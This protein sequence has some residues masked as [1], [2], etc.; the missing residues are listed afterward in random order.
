MKPTA[1]V[2]LLTM[3]ACSGKDADTAPADDTASEDADTDADTDTDTS[4]AYGGVLPSGEYLLGFAVAPV[5]NLLVPFQA[6]VTP[7]A[8]GDRPGIASLS[9]APTSAAY[10]VGEVAVTATDIRVEADGSFVVDLGVFI[11]PGAYAPT[12]SDVELT[13]TL[14]G[15]IAED[16]TM[17]GDLS[18][19]LLSFG[20]SLEGSTFG[21]VAWADRESGAE[22]S[23]DGGDE[24]DLP[25]ITDCPTLEAGTV[26]GFPSGGVERTFE[27]V[28]PPGADT[29]E[30]M[31]VVFAFHGLGG[32]PAQFLEDH[33]LP[34]A[35][36][37]LGAIVVVPRATD[38]GG[39]E[40]W[41]PYSSPGGNKDVAFF[42]DM[43]T[44]VSEQYPVDPDRVHV[45]GFSNGGLVTGMLLTVRSSVIASVAPFAGGL[46]Q[47]FPDDA[48]AI[49]T[50]MT[51]G[52]PEDEAAGTDF[53]R[54][55]LEMQETLSERGHPLVVC[56]HDRQH[57]IDADWWPWV[58][59]FFADHPRTEAGAPYASGLPEVFP[60]WC[61]VP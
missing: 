29:A 25:R 59:R 61:R 42:D 39:T 17:C 56:E 41:D 14:S 28:L 57:E 48:R 38:L 27:L 13:A 21:T 33:P 24:E 12:G 31:P 3:I 1:L 11:L 51:W 60:E 20:I 2:V 5:N 54:L 37:A 26:T 6:V 55:A 15:T 44:C 10:D 43:L 23:C 47:A 35:A 36:E 16:G 53:H 58:M 52:G 9:L 22:I 45:M 7:T 34:P 18:G 40:A 46:G 19:E 8:D 4:E 30:D 32:S 49:P 50:L